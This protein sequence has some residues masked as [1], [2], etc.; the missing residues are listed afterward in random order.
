MLA[1]RNAVTTTDWFVI[2]GVLL[3]IVAVLIWQSLRVRTLADYCVAGRRFGWFML[4]L[5][6][7]GSG[8]STDRPSAITAG[9]W[10]FGLAGA[11]WQIV[12]LPTIPLMWLVA[13]AFR[14]VRA[15]TVADF[16][17]IRFGTS[18]AILY[19]ILA[20]LYSTTV[21]AGILFTSSIVLE[22]LSDGLAEETAADLGW[23]VPVINLDAALAPPDVEGQDLV[24]WRA[25][26]GRD[27]IV[28]V[29]A[30]ALIIFAVFA[31]LG[32]SIVVDALQGILLTALTI[33][34]AVSCID[35]LGG[36]EG[37]AEAGA[38]RAGLFELIPPQQVAGQLGSPPIT[39][40]LLVVL[41][42][43]AATGCVALPQLMCVI[44]AGRNE[45]ASR[46]GCAA[47][48]L[49]RRCLGFAYVI[50]G[51]ASV[52]LFLG[53]DSPLLQSGDPADAILH[54][55]LAEAAANPVVEVPLVGSGM[56]DSADAAFARS[57]LGRVARILLPAIMPGLLGLLIATLCAAV[58]SH[59][60]TQ[61]IA[62]GTMLADLI[63]RPAARSHQS[64]RQT[65]WRCRLCGA[66]IVVAA[67]VLQ[68]SCLNAIDLLKLLIG[69][70]AAIGLSIWMGLCW[71]R[72]NTPAVW[73]SV[74]M[75]AAAWLLVVAYPEQI[76]FSFP[77]L[78][79]V[80]F[81]IRAGQPVM[82]DAWQMTWALSAGL[83]GGA[84]TALMTLP[85]ASDRLHHFFGLLRTPVRPDEDN[86][87]PCR[88]PPDEL[89][90][91]PVVRFG[92]FQFPRPSAGD[93][94][95]GSFLT[96]A[97]VAMTLAIVWVSQQV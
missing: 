16:F 80:M 90:L 53:P 19:S 11:L 71:V 87:V 61:V 97:A 27:L 17:T 78:E 7:F 75:S 91:T 86:H 93:V 72:W 52:A 74:M 60:A 47:G 36:L 39:I 37:V 46:F 59:G 79:D 12:W 4:T 15:F 8:T 22:S 31:G 65:L 1:P 29:L 67:L 26:S 28:G 88:I 66:A 23:S 57:V 81:V 96:A 33:V 82:T 55:R 42:I 69:I 94:L 95:G 35:R 68:A 63:K 54:E 44:G 13:P 76:L 84:V 92:S 89:N 14:R 5:S 43:A 77:A 25:L 45:A 30:T 2:A 48:S 32:G 21:I 9:G 62:A 64:V 41:S 56:Q 6:M 10:R 49:L 18:T 38:M 51:L 73:L 70:P 50:I 24:Q 83:I 85:V 58:I 34:L 40:F 20:V 3:L